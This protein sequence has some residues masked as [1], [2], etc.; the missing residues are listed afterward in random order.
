MQLHKFY[1]HTSYK[2][3]SLS[4]ASQPFMDTFGKFFAILPVHIMDMI[5]QQ[6]P[7]CLNQFTVI[8]I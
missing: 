2:P 7:L 5:V 6:Q 1:K 3:L 8:I 4:V